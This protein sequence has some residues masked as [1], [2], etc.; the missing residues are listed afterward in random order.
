MLKSIITIVK[1]FKNII[2]TANKA[3]IHTIHKRTKQ[4]KVKT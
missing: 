1:L 3:S 2:L 4:R